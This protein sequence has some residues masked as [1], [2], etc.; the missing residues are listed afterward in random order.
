MNYERVNLPNYIEENNLFP[1]D[2]DTPNISGTDIANTL[3]TNISGNYNTTDQT[4]G[5]IITVPQPNNFEPQSI[6]RIEE[7][8]IFNEYT[9]MQN[10]TTVQEGIVDL[11]IAIDNEQFYMIYSGTTLSGINTLPIYAEQVLNDAPGLSGVSIKFNDVLYA[12]DRYQIRTYS[13][14]TFISE[15]FGGIY[16]ITISF[17]IYAMSTIEIHELSDLIQQFFVVK[18]FDLWDK[19]G[20]TIKTWTKSGESE[21]QHLNEYIYKSSLN[22]SG[23]VEW[24]EDR[25]ILLLDSFTVS[26]IPYG[27]F[28]SGTYVPIGVSSIQKP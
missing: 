1:W 26:A 17:D 16:D 27:S 3:F 22:I 18:K 6:E 12:G 14:E 13:G 20:F 11:A 24:H 21:T 4:T 7:I 10:P 23:M 25:G 15:R 5:I 9:Y 28:Y 19:A 2:T 8:K